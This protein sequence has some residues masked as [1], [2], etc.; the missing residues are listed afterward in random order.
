[1]EDLNEINLTGVDLTQVSEYGTYKIML[2]MAMKQAI[3]T[4]VVIGYLL[5]RARDTNILIGSS[6]KSVTEMALKEYGLQKDQVSRYIAINDRFSENG[7]SPRLQKQYEHFGI[8][9]LQE[10]LQLP[11][12]IIAELTPQ[13]TRSDIQEIKKEYHEENKK[14]DIEVMLETDEAEMFSSLAEKSLYQYFKDN[15]GAYEKIWD[16]ACR[17]KYGLVRTETVIENLA[18]SEIMKEYV[19]LSGIGKI[20]IT[21]NAETGVFTFT[22]MRN[23]DKDSVN[24]QTLIKIF[25]R[26]FTPAY[27]KDAKHTWERVYNIDY[28]E[29]EVI[30]DNHDAIT[31][32]SDTIPKESEIVSEKPAKKPEKIHEKVKRKLQTLKQDREKPESKPE[33]QSENATNVI[34]TQCESISENKKDWKYI[35]YEEMA[36]V[37]EKIRSNISDRDN[38]KII[39]NA[40]MLIKMTEELQKCEQTQDIPGQ[41]SMDE[42]TGK[43]EA[44][45]LHE[46]GE[47]S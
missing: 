8:A 17:T 11:D 25:I 43:D 41:M 9:K 1:M 46:A 3:E 12:A 36:A 18:P 16:I 23:G 27:A 14:T 42:L 33:K 4:F 40:Q 44:D 31:K 6:Y 20:L 32:E 28:P 45:T 5:K 35:M 22:N 39:L 10:M 7:Y 24:A 30:T 15:T 13:M 26:I 47:Q 38:E 21:V 29:T 19:R 37:N 34:N 2:D